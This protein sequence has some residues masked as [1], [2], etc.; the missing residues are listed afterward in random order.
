MIPG[1]KR[2]PFLLLLLLHPLFP[3]VLPGQTSPA[4]AGAATEKDAAGAEV[5][6]GPQGFLSIDY[7]G[8]RFV[9]PFR[10]IVSISRH[11][12]LVDAGGKVHEL[13]IDTHGSVIARY[14]YLESPLDANP[15]NA[16]QI[17]NSRI[18]KI[19]GMVEERTGQDTRMVVKHYPDTTHAKTVEFNVSS[20]EQLERIYDH[21]YDDWVV[22]NGK[23]DGRILRIR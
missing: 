17:V 5:V 11:D 23:G 12:F 6:S 18:E 13:T 20:I 19:R 1:M 21:I 9:T 3:A 8:G 15:L 10:S 7:K 16:A 4:P 22:K 14:Y 2:C